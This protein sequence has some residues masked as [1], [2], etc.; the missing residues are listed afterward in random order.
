MKLHIHMRT[1]ALFCMWLM[2][3]SAELAL[4]RYLGGFIVF[5]W[6][7]SAGLLTFITEYI[8][9]RKRGDEDSWGGL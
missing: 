3:T 4:A 5:N 7:I 8:A 6:I 2:I 9:N 1:I